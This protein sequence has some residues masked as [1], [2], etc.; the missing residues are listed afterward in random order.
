MW[1]RLR[2]RLRLRLWMQTGLTPLIEA[3][4]GGDLAMAQLLLQYGADPNAA[5]RVHA[6]G[7]KSKVRRRGDGAGGWQWWW[8]E[9]EEVTVEA[10][11]AF[12][13]GLGG[14]HWLGAVPSVAPVDVGD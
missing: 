14:R 2:L 11:L 4:M 8:E 3:C 12:G 5:M 7:W 9:D 6:T 10:M 13:E 1:P